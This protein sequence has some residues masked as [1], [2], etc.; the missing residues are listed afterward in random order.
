M[1]GPTAIC[2]SVVRRAWSPRLAS[3]LLASR[4]ARSRRLAVT[5]GETD[6]FG[7]AF[8]FGVTL[9]AEE[10]LGLLTPRVL[11]LHRLGSLTPELGAQRT[12]SSLGKPSVGVLA[13]TWRLGSLT[14]ELATSGLKTGRSIVVL[15]K[16]SVGVLAESSIA[17]LK[18]AK[19]GQRLGDMR[20]ARFPWLEQ[21]A[22]MIGGVPL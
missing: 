1:P 8:L 13:E 16:P 4:K 22:S 2:S 9:G 21:T 18:T 6:G 11:F 15:G 7:R 20:V 17:P 12:G 3:S 14:P 19:S 5:A 10:S